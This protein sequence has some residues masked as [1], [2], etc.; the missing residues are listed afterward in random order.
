MDEA[1]CQICDEEMDFIGDVGYGLPV[2][3][4]TGLIVPS[5]FAG[6]YGSTPCCCSCYTLHQLWS[7]RFLYFEYM[8]LDGRLELSCDELLDYGRAD[9]KT[10]KTVE[11]TSGS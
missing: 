11:F 3:T 4:T 6:D 9:A 8:L 1:R 7:T 10:S 5:C 2:S